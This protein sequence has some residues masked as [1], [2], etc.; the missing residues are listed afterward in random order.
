MAIS[1]NIDFDN[2]Y[3]IDAISE[4]LR[5]ADFQ[6][7]LHDGTKIPLKIEISDEPHH[8]LHNV[9]NLAF[10]PLDSRGRIDDQAELEHSNYSKVFS[11][12]LFTGLTYLNSNPNHYLG[13]DGSSNARAYLYYKFLQNNYDYLNQ[14]LLP[15]CVMF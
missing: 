15:A 2:L 12:I 6:S 8:L 10:G 3:S 9:Y 11:T 7:E 4:D 14:F 13:I 5:E 1:V